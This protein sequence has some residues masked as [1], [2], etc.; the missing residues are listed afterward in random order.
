MENFVITNEC[1]IFGLNQRHRPYLYGYFQIQNE[2]LTFHYTLGLENLPFLLP[3]ATLLII[4]FP[5]QIFCSQLIY[6]FRIFK[7]QINVFQIFMFFTGSLHILLN[8]N[9]IKKY[10]P[11]SEIVVHRFSD[12]TSNFSTSIAK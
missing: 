5:I 3:P 9:N 8:V 2:A 12:R 1:K 4:D 6:M 11:K 10:I 7:F